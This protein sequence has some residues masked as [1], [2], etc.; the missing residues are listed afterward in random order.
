MIHANFGAARSNAESN[1]EVGP[2]YSDA[3]PREADGACSAASQKDAAQD[4]IAM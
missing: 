4:D 3:V 1:I 2:F